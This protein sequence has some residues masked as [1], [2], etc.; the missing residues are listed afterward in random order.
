MAARVRREPGVKARAG[1][2][3]QA[4]KARAGEREQAAQPRAG[5]EQAVE[6]RAGEREAAEPRAGKRERTMVEA[7]AGVPGQKDPGNPNESAAPLVPPTRKLEVLRAAA[8]TCLA[9]PLG[10]RA[11]QTVFGE[12]KPHAKLFLIG[13]QPGDEEDRTGRPFVGPAGRMLDRALAEAG[14]ARREV[15]VT[16]AVKHFNYRPLGKKRLHAKPEWK[17]L[18][19]CRPWLRAELAAVQ[20]EA[21]I[22]MGASAAQ[23]LLGRRFTVL[24]NRGRVFETPWA[25]GLLVTYHPSAILR[26]PTHEAREETF[27]AFVADLQLAQRLLRGDSLA[28][29]ALP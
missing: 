6:A 25:K 1:K 15:Y 8:A 7:H 27:R 12:G 17:H 18:E 26:M 2:R 13:E 21:V 9:C 11:T 24:K 20:P 29:S 3:E 19:A 4:V 16:N 14:L 10:P 5:R 23:S 28:L 22:C